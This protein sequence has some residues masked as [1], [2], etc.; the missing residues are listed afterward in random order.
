MYNQRT[1]N[2]SSLKVAPSKQPS[3]L[4]ADTDSVMS[5]LDEY[6]VVYPE[7]FYKLQPYIMMVC[8]QLDV[9]GDSMPTQNMIEQMTNNVYSDILEMYPDIA[10][11]VRE[12]E[13]SG[14]NS[15]ETITRPRR[16][17]NCCYRRRGIFRDLIDILFLSEYYRRRRR[18]YYY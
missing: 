10:E 1:A 16:Y 12:S 13:N 6:R 4:K 11:Y 8:D 17:Y 3:Y 18:R 15:M 2:E 5:A 14:K 9:Y 7:I